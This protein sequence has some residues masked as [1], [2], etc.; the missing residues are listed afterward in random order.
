IRYNI[1]SIKL[2]RET[3]EHKHGK[4][5]TEG[6]IPRNLLMFAMPMLISNFL[7]TGYSIINTVWLGNI[8]GELAVG[9]VAISF[10]IVFILIAVAG[11]LGMSATILVSQNYGAKNYPMINKVMNN[12][13]MVSVV[14]GVVCTGLCMLFSHYIIS[15][16]N[17]PAQIFPLAVGYLNIFL[18]GM[19]FLFPTFIIIS[20]LRG[21]GDTVTPL[22][23]LLISIFINAILDPLLIIGIAPFP[24]LGL[25][26]AAV[27]S[28]VSQL[29]TTIAGLIYINKK[30]PLLK[31][32]YHKFRPD[33]K[34]IGLIF[35]IGV[36]TIVQQS[37][38]SIG[39]IFVTAYVNFFGE[40][41]IAAFGAV[42]RVESIAILPAMS[43]SMAVSTLTGQAIGAGKHHKIKEVFKWGIVLNCSII[44]SLSLL[45][46]LFPRIILNAFVHDP[47]VL[48]IG[49]NYFHIVASCYVFFAV[50]FVV[51]G[52][53]NGSGNTLITMFV[54]LITL[55]LIRV[56]LGYYLSQKTALGINGV[57][58]AISLSFFTAM[59]VSLAYYYS[60]LW[61]K[62][63][64]LKH[65]APA[66]EIEPI[67]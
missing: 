53:I 44:V 25:N 4:D 58:I 32:D 16:M 10:P 49:A 45:A 65:V 42:G 50:L 59:V 7:M 41:A 21:I 47:E 57:W 63:T 11:G 8:V 46:V 9:A 38:I 48:R 33:F 36:P 67:E 19:F 43:I 17:T 20:A 24:K 51:N 30:F 39:M 34:I 27:A 29:I 60:G 40:K 6:S 18:L 5:L 61:K 54:S 23:F 56:P 22:I 12:A 37:L 28:V 66:I 55:W 2:L 35:K 64:V 26:G 31:L 52:I 3:M 1:I 62:D 13:F 14:A 15:A